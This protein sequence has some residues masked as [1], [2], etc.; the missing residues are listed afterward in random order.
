MRQNLPSIVIVTVLFV[1]SCC[2][3]QHV[4]PDAAVGGV[5][6]V[7]LV[8]TCLLALPVTALAGMATS[9]FQR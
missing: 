7:A 5:A 2:F 9:L 1:A 3:V 8:I 6:G 4:S